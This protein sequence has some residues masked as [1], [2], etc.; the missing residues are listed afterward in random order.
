M[1]TER[2]TC[3]AGR[4]AVQQSHVEPSDC[5]YQD[6]DTTDDLLYTTSALEL[7]HEAVNQSINQSIN[8]KHLYQCAINNCV[9][10]CGPKYTLGVKM[11]WFQVQTTVLSCMLHLEILRDIIVY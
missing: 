5:Q 10:E 8:K 2:H 3:R 4:A 9:N 7:T 6:E 1:K 11:A